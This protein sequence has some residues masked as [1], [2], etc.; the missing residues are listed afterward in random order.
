MTDKLNNIGGQIAECTALSHICSFNCCNQD[1]PNEPTK[2][3][4]SILL[5][6]GEIESVAAERKRHIIITLNDF[7][8]GKLG[9]C[10]PTILNQSECNPEKNFKPLDCRS[11]PFAPAFRNGALILLVDRRRCPLGLK[12]LR[13]HHGLILE[14]WK[15]IIQ[16]KSDVRQ[17]IEA[18]DLNG[19]EE[20]NY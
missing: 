18:L 10:D 6:P 4:S 20:F 15:E 13:A 2:P 12:A 17:W 1:S 8:G 9:Y 19:Y 3:E 14:K 11:Y 5:Y 7:H 16:K